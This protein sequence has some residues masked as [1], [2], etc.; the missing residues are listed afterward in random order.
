MPNLVCYLSEEWTL[1]SAVQNLK[2]TEMSSSLDGSSSTYTMDCLEAMETAITCSGT[3]IEIALKFGDKYLDLSQHEA[4]STLW[5]KSFH[6]A[7]EIFDMPDLQEYIVTIERHDI[8][9]KT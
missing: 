7:S 6:C 3:P 2:V 5:E 1:Q 8:E 9:D 4:M